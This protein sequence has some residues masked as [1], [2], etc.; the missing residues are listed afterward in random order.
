MALYRTT[1]IGSLSNMVF[2][3]GFG[4]GAR[5]ALP[6]STASAQLAILSPLT[7]IKMAK[8]ADS[9]AVIDPDDGVKLVAPCENER[10]TYDNRINSILL[11]RT[12]SFTWPQRPGEWPSGSLQQK[13][14]WNVGTHP[15]LGRYSEAL[16]LSI[17]SILDRSGMEWQRFYPIR[18]ETIDSLDDNNYI[19]QA[20][21]LMIDVVPDTTT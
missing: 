10:K 19:V 8:D 20:V 2:W 1:L 11:A 5:A 13:K 4:R 17:S 21:V 6:F 3:Q 7:T 15:I 16:K 18:V 9:A 14:F 12:S